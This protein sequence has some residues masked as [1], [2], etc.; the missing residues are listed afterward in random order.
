MAK[1]NAHQFGTPNTE[2]L[3]YDKAKRALV[4]VFKRR[5][6]IGLV[7]Q[8][9]NV[10]TGEWTNTNSHISAEID[11][12]YEY[13]LKGWLLFG[14]EDCHQMWLESIE[15]IHKYL[16]DEEQGELWYGESDMISGKRTAT[17]YGAL[18]AFFP[19]VLS[20]SGDL[21]KAKRLQASCF[22]MWAQFG[23]EPERL[24]YKT[25]QVEEAAYPLR[26]EIIESA[27]YLYHYTNDPQY[28]EMGKECFDGLVK[29]CRT[30]AGY[31]ALSNV[32]TKEQSDGMQS[33]LFAET[34]KYLIPV[35]TSR[36]I[37]L[38]RYLQY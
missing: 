8:N 25:M 12:Y 36:D 9:I 30:D 3:Y 31:A 6:S 15:A 32:V 34:F 1:P 14:D 26:P 22:K 4:E 27:Y 35:R 7:G 21:E 23:I 29:Y 37:K 19:A 10:E 13:L 38:R 18:D 2:P 11:S 24:N 28:L 5:S 16:A 20:L 17:L 33:F